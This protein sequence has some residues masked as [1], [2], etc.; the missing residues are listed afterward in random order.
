[1]SCN[2][3]QG[4]LTPCILDFIH[5][6]SKNNQTCE[7]LQQ[8]FIYLTMRCRLELKPAFGGQDNKITG[9]VQVLQNQMCTNAAKPVR[10]NC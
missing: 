1:M 6:L 3:H 9:E 4:A 7:I 10:G 8:L 2:D 5:Y